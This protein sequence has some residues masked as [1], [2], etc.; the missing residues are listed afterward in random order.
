MD[1]HPVELKKARSRLYNIFSVLFCQPEVDIQ[2]N[3]SL[4]ESLSDNLCSLDKGLVNEALQLKALFDKYPDNELLVEYTRLFI[5]PFKTLAAPYSSI[6]LDPNGT[7][8]GL[9]TQWVTEFYNTCGLE[10]TQSLNDLPDHIAVE[11]EFLHYLSSQEISEMES[12]NPKKAEA[13]FKSQEI[14]L[15]H[16]LKRWAPLFCNQIISETNNDYYRTLAL[17][18]KSFIELGLEQA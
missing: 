8:F 7:I 17:C 16:H 14:F 11:M 2:G 13:L 3:S 4:Y 12:G 9:E 10:I 18:F 1:K 6:Y 15:S 5:G